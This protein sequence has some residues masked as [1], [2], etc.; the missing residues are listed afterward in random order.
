MNSTPRNL[1]PIWWLPME[2]RRSSVPREGLLS[3][4]ALRPRI[5]LA[6]WDFGWVSLLK[7]RLVFL[8]GFWVAFGRLGKHG[9]A[10]D[11][12]FVREAGKARAR[13]G[14]GIAR[15][16]GGCFPGLDSVRNLCSSLITLLVTR[17]CLVLVR[18]SSFVSPYLRLRAAAPRLPR[19]V[20]LVLPA[21]LRLVPSA[22]SRLPR[23]ARLPR[24][25]R[26]VCLVP[27]ASP[28][29]PCFACRGVT[30][31]PCLS[32]FPSRAVTI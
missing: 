13:S 11:L 7:F 4:L 23:R 20:C 27:P 30:P 25:P 32:P 29:P 28:R 17:C 1:V 8:L 10:W 15:I 24:L 16:R 14:L 31:C 26:P 18:C 21:S 2:L 6:C 3:R 12:D 22:S 19:P 9:R 5:L